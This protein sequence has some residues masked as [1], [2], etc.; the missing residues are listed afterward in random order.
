MRGH[1]IP[2]R[3]RTRVAAFVSTTAVVSNL[4]YF[5]SSALSGTPHAETSDFAEGIAAYD[6]GDVGSAFRIWLSA[7][8]RGDPAAQIALA[9]LYR[10][11]EVPS[12]RSLTEAYRWYR[13]AALAGDPIGQIN[14]AELLLAGEGVTHDPA[15]ALQWLRAAA[16]QEN[17][18]AERR[19]Q[20]LIES[21][22]EKEAAALEARA[23]QIGPDC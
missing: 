20:K 19:I 2:V 22:S 13:R 7:A 4:L 23:I 9:D 21:M 3:I 17:D 5:G 14:T 16:A 11:G 8:K 15:C 12:G 6:G 10:G 1:P 18:W